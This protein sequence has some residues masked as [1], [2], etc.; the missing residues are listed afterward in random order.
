MSSIYT[1]RDGG[2][3]WELDR[4]TR[5]LN[6]QG[7]GAIPDY[8]PFCGRFP[9]W[10]P[11]RGQIEEARVGEGITRIGNYAF[12]PY[13]HGIYSDMRSP[14]RRVS[15]PPTLES[16]GRFAFRANIRL[17]FFDLSGLVRLE[18]IEDY[19]FASCFYARGANLSGCKRLSHVSNTAFWGCD[20]L[21]YIDLSGCTSLSDK[22]LHALRRDIPAHIPIIMPDGKVCDGLSRGSN[23]KKH[24]VLI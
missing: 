18:A 22:T 7:R 10:L 5:L 2:I 9:S 11:L 16:I 3:C 8:D 15:F 24:R 23:T 20:D 13:D 6:V 14:L 19:A 1:G 4:K 12:Y 17:V 21:S